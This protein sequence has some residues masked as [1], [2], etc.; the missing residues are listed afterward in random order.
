MMRILLIL[1]LLLAGCTTQPVSQVPPTEPGQEAPPPLRQVQVAVAPGR[2]NNSPYVVFG[3]TYAVMPSSAGYLEI[4]IASWYGQEF[5]GRPTSN[6]EKF[7]MYQVSAAHKSLPLPT[8]VR[9]T[10]LDNGR[11][12][13]LRVN[14]RGPFHDDRLIDLSFETARKLGFENKGTAPVVVEALDEI[15]YPERVG[16][17]PLHES[18]YLQ[19]GAFARLEGAEV[20]Q[21]KIG[22][23]VSASEFAGTDVRILQSELAPE[24]ILHKVWLGPIKSE[25][26]RDALARLV[27]S[28]KLGVPLRVRVD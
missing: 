24:V 12:V 23:L 18:F 26:E 10:N 13:V 27:E 3:K 8:V 20:L 16:T 7:D 6:G 1:M 25:P 15:N 14:D 19:L 21:R 9:V 11:K 22:D 17:P 5:N 2:G 28:A 4:G